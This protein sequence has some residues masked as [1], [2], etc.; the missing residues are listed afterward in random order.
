[1]GNQSEGAIRDSTRSKAPAVLPGAAQ[2][3]MVAIHRSPQSV[4]PAG[5]EHSPDQS[6][7]GVNGPLV[8]MELGVNR[9]QLSNRAHHVGRKRSG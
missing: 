7:P 2:Q 8:A 6:E 4:L 9:T 3:K 5:P 1:M